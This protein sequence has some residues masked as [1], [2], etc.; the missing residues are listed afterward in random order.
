MKAT[1]ISKDIT[2]KELGNLWF[3]DKKK[4]NSDPSKK[5][6]LQT[7]KDV[8]DF[9]GKIKVINI[10]LEDV[11]KYAT[12]LDNKT[13]TIGYCVAKKN[14]RQTLYKHGYISNNNIKRKINMKTSTFAQALAGHRTCINW[15]KRFAKRL[16]IPYSD[17]FDEHSE[18]VKYATSDK[19]KNI[20]IIR[21]VLGYGCEIGIINE[22]VADLD[23]L[24]KLSWKKPKKYSPATKEDLNNLFLYVLDHNNRK[25]A[26]SIVLLM[27]AK[28]Q[29]KKIAGLKWEDI[30]FENSIINIKREVSISNIKIIER[31][32]TESIKIDERILI[33]L[34]DYQNY[35]NH[36]NVK[37]EYVFPRENGEMTHPTTHKT[38]LRRSLMGIGKPEL[39]IINFK[40][41]NLSI[42]D[43]SDELFD[44]IKPKGITEKKKKKVKSK[45]KSCNRKLSSN[46]T[47][48]KNEMKKYGFKT[49]QEYFDFINF[50]EA[51]EKSN[52][53]KEARGEMV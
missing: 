15:C 1:N 13:R 6:I 2:F 16:N 24:G 14:I 3:N 22:N 47:E 5:K 25:L 53:K 48:V 49:Y 18:E 8:D 20:S 30:D 44:Y 36:K 12:R 32:Y 23:H 38:F 41:A 29:R 28:F 9:L 17:L 27:V 11:Q 31:D 33:L 19:Q 26:L 37:S 43:V 34:E 52:Q 42:D 7:K 45:N 21:N 10:T 39:G 46:F 40:I 51:V 4:E 35:L 50:L